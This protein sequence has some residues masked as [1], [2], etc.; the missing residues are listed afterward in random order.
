MEDWL[1]HSS[2]SFGCVITEL[3]RKG[4]FNNV[5][6]VSVVM[7]IGGLQHQIGKDDTASSESDEEEYQQSKWQQGGDGRRFLAFE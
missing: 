4:E 5:R 1:A 6:A 3:F 2:P 7:N